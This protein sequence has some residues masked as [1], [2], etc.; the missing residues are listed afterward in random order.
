MTQSWGS[1]KHKLQIASSINLLMLSGTTRI[2]SGNKFPQQKLGKEL[3]NSEQKKKMFFI[4]QGSF[5]RN[6]NSFRCWK[7]KLVGKQ[8]ISLTLGMNDDGTHLTL[9]ELK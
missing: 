9:M 3:I 7:E 4:I 1:V 8:M 6:E 2:I 5:E